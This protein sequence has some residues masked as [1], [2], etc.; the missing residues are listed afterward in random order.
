VN[1]ADLAAILEPYLASRRWYVAYSGG[2]D[3]HVLLHAVAGLRDELREALPPLSAI[4]INHQINPQAAAW[5]AHCQTVCAELG[6][7]LIME[8]VDIERDAGHG[9][10]AAARQARY[11]AF[12]RH[13]GSGE[14]LL[15]AHHRDDQVETLLLRL[16]RGSGLAGLAS[17]PASRALG[18]GRL[19]RPLLAVTR[20]EIIGYAQQN[21]LCWI[22]DD[23]NDNEGFDRNFLR[24]RVLPRVAERWPAYRDTLQRVID[25]AAEADGLLKEL[26]ALDYVDAVAPDSALQIDTCRQLNAARQRNLIFYWLQQQ[27]LPLPS[28]EQLAQVLMMLVARDDA[29]PC[30][31]WPGAELRRFRGHLFA[32][33]PLPELPPDID[34]EWPPQPLSIAGLG[35]LRALPVNGAGLRGDRHYRVRNRRGGERCRPLGRA[36]SQT[37][38]KLLQEHDIKPWLRDRLPLIYCGDEIAAVA[39]LWICEG[40]RAASH[41]DGWRIEWRPPRSQ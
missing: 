32:M 41:E 6:I 14:L 20:A 10:E 31:T 33:Q 23:S 21:Q 2:V 34:I 5:V 3:S 39:D 36:H 19:L 26:A 12:E 9:L 24:L 35:E 22:H 27:Q 30:V 29:E 4:H 11:A 1:P 8:T 40:Y 18:R 16:L 17:M 38:K 7:E 13:I 25:N 28:R 37:L 15:Q